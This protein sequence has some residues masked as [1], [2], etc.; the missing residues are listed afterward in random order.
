MSAPQYDAWLKRARRDLTERTAKDYARIIRRLLVTNLDLEIREFTTEDCQRF[1]DSYPSG[2][3][4]VVRAALR[5][6]FRPLYLDGS[7]P[8]NP[9]DRVDVPVAQKQQSTDVF[10]EPEVAR[11]FGLP[12]PDGPLFVLMIECGLRK[13]ECIALRRRDI[14][15]TREY[16]VVKSRKEP[17]VRL[18]ARAVQAVRELD[19]KEGLRPADHLWSTRP[20]GGAIVHRERPISD[21][22]F[23]GWYRK[24][25]LQ[26]GVDHR[27]ARTTHRTFEHRSKLQE[28][29]PRTSVPL[30]PAVDRLLL[31]RLEA[32][33]PELA[34]SY[35]QVHIDLADDARLS[36][37]GPAGEIREVMRAV[38]HELSPDDDV[39]ARSWYVGHED[40]PTQAERIRHILESRSETET[41][42][43]NTAGIVEEKV[44]TFGRDLY[45][46]ASRALHTGAQREELRK[47]VRWVEAVLIEILPP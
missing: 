40:R 16:L 15:L 38:I 29:A 22:T 23:Q 45:R 11:L 47:I 20:G 44:A 2:T 36:F 39:R 43:T 30:P 41:S 3:R 5:S 34:A 14:D 9:V 32:L 26:A 28:T 42:A 33:Q 46:R 25:L 13:R 21:T 4:G 6:F 10:S 1:L 17:R 24:A 8:T 7:I 19:A 31:H 37:L 27:E 35:S 12:P 18:S